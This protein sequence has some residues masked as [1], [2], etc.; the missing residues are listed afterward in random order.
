[1]RKRRKQ[2]QR[3]QSRTMRAWIVALALVTAGL[4][5]PACN[6]GEDGEDTGNGGG[7]GMDAAMDAGE[8]TGGTSEDG[9]GSDTDEGGEDGT[10]GG[11]DGGSMDDAG[12]VE[13]LDGS[14][15]MDGGGPP[16]KTIYRMYAATEGLAGD[17]GYFAVDFEEGISA[18]EAVLGES[19]YGSGNVGITASAGRTFMFNQDD[20][21]PAGKLR[22]IAVAEGGGFQ[23]TEMTLPDGT[24][25]PRGAAV[26]ETRGETVVS[27]YM[28]PALYVFDSGGMRTNTTYDTSQ[29]D[30]DG[31][32]ED[33]DP[34]VTELAADG[35]YVLVLLKMVDQSGDN[36]A[37][38]NNSHLAVLDAKN[39]SFVDTNPDSNTV[40]A[41]DLGAKNASAG[42]AST[43][44]GK[45]AVGLYGSATAEDGKIVLIDSESD[46][47]YSVGGTIISQN[48]LGGKPV[49]FVLT[50]ED[51][52]YAL[53]ATQGGMTTVLKSF[54]PAENG[55]GMEATTINDIPG[56]S[57]A[58]CIS[59]D[60]K[61]LFV[62]NDS[63]PMNNPPGGIGYYVF[64]TEDDSRLNDE[65]I[66]NLVPS[67][68]CV[69]PTTTEEI[70]ETPGDAGMGDDGMDDDDQNIEPDGGQ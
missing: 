38:P 26:V 8:D 55:E 2:T 43:G 44:T 14:M 25:D 40:E 65:A 61:R 29:F 30:L 64:D 12:D 34:E 4:A 41:L 45:F 27:S 67:N 13:N 31:S 46:G 5:G 21:L 36:P 56:P 28:D 23:V 6:G 32:A 69:A 19:S 16:T 70:I 7:G 15:G 52:G 58:I 68:G 9:G 35:D 3:R 47:K 1:M 54:G 53:V 37:Y 59:P 66:T 48:D 63:P 33:N 49:D 62:G 57:G 39:G 20:A 24:V 60:R 22:E 17:S 42:L 18:M 10:S 50:G 11:E 51:S